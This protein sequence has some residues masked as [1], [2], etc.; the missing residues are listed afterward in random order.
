MMI[1]RPV[2]E[3]KAKVAFAC[4]LIAASIR[5]VEQTSSFAL[6]YFRNAPGLGADLGRSN[7]ALHEGA[8][9]AKNH[10]AATRRLYGGHE[11]DDKPIKFLQGRNGRP[12]KDVTRMPCVNPTVTA[13]D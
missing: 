7:V 1:Q 10:Q 8:S 12:G 3:T 2:A 6:R 5:Q 9:A 4:A 11:A 13:S